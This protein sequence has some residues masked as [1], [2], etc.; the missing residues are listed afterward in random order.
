ME[1]NETWKSK[2]VRSNSQL[3]AKI[4]KF[5]ETERTRKHQETPTK[6]EKKEP[7]HT[8]TRAQEA[9]KAEAAHAAGS[10]STT[11]CTSNSR[12]GTHEKQAKPS[13]QQQHA[14]T[15]K[16]PQHE[17]IANPQQRHTHTHPERRHEPHTTRQANPTLERKTPELRDTALYFVFESSVDLRLPTLPY[18]LRG[19][20]RLNVVLLPNKNFPSYGRFK[21]LPFGSLLTADLAM[22][23]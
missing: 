9:E 19:F 15:H 2:K 3:R 8:R 10:N 21:M 4:R 5:Q 17:R 18:H 13:K 11:R 1:W 7:N 6:R 12:A 16:R 14:S 20:S 22:D 23:F